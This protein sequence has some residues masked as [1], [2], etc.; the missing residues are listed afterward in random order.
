MKRITKIVI[1]STITSILL[2]GCAA[3]LLPKKQKI[4][5]NANNSESVVYISNEEIGKGTSTTTKVKREGTLQVVTQTPGFKDEYNVLFPQG[6]DPVYI[7]LRLLSWACFIIPGY[8][9]SML[10]FSMDKKYKYNKI[11]DFSNKIKYVERGNKKYVDLEAID[12]SIKNKKSDIVFINV[13]YKQ[14][15]NLAFKEAELIYEKD[16]AKAA[17]KEEKKKKKKGRTLVTDGESADELKYDDTKFSQKI[18]KTLKKSGFVDTVNQVFLDDQNTVNLQGSIK[19]ATIFQVSKNYYSY[20]R[21]RLKIVWK[22]KNSFGEVLDSIIKEDFSGDFMIP[23][24]YGNQEE[25]ENKIELMFA[26]AVDVSF[27]KM[28]GDPKFQKYLTAETY[29]NP[30]SAILELPL[31][32]SVVTSAEDGIEASVIIKRKDKGH[33][34]GFAITNNG[35]ILTNYHVIAGDQANKN[36]EFKVVMS[37]GNEVEAKMIRVNKAKDIVL[38]K[39]EENFDKAFSLG[40]EKSFKK[41]QEVYCIGTPKSIEL[42]QTVS[43]GILSNERNVNNNSV[44]QLSMSINAGNSGGPLFGKNGALHGVVQ[45]KLVGYATEGIGFAIP[46]YMIDEYLGIKYK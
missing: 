6:K 13:P 20:N 1:F 30:Y 41:L 15:L 18:Y 9:E 21:A 4:V 37:N 35:Y 44:L 19:K 14:D 46:A 10:V 33:G 32:K 36:A 27:Q 26:D 40:T 2:S 3:I 42:G 8:Y 39:V 43:L 22:I 25:F 45:S 11:N 17:K 31:P 12:L 28:L 16:K 5:A 29:K 24:S 38:L 34:S 7:G 23:S